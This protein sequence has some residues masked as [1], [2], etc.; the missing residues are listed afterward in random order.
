MTKTLLFH[1]KARSKRDV[2]IIVLFAP[3]L[4]LSACESSRGNSDGGQCPAG[5][6]LRYESPG[7]GAAATPVCGSSAQD[8]C[9]RAVCSCQGQTIS[10]CD[11]APEPFSAFGACPVPDSGV[12][13]AVDRANDL[14]I[15]AQDVGVDGPPVCRVRSSD[16]GPTSAFSV[17]PNGTP[18]AATTCSAAC[19]DS[20]WPVY[21]PPNIDT[22]LPY[23][24]CAADTPS[25]STLAIVP[26]V[27]GTSNG[28]THAFNCSCE[29]GT[30]ICRIR[31]LGTALC[32]PC[33]DAGVSQIDQSSVSDGPQNAVEA[34]Q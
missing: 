25:C 31:F 6:V 21:G 7:C 17:L 8:A 26:C 32:M 11:Y 24:A 22:A 16:Y 27:C 23:G 29:A 5:Q 18:A 14:G 34:N 19:G 20:A 30:W 12:D 2:A 4:F 28:P 15:D 9:Y 13:L 3:A 10:R 33:P 1:E